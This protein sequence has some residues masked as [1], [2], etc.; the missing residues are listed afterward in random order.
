MENE[1]RNRLDLNQI[2]QRAYLSAYFEVS[3]TFVDGR[4]DWVKIMF[5]PP[6]GS[7]LKRTEG[8]DSTFYGA[9]KDLLEIPSGYEYKWRHTKSFI[10]KELGIDEDK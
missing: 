8:S 5:R 3:E 7:D 9:L 2:K 1:Y 6:S 10:R 4:L